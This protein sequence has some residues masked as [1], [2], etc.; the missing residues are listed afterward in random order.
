MN[1]T[2]YDKTTIESLGTGD[3]G[4]DE[5][6]FSAYHA[7]HFLL[8]VGA[9]GKNYL[10]AEVKYQPAF[11]LWDLKNNWREDFLWHPEAP[12]ILPGAVL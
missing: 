2:L 4:F 1:F 9:D 6:R 12:P 5:L 3:I 10:G 8:V 7:A 11:I